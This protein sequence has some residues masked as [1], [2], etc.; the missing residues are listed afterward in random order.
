MLLGTLGTILLRNMS[1]RKGMFR[2][3]YGNKEGKKILR[4]GY[5]S[6]VLRSKLFDLKKIQFRLIP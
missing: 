5:E 2:A 3:G 1:T 6:K 4:A